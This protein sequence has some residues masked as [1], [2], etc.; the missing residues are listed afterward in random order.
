MEMKSCIAIEF[1]HENVLKF[2]FLSLYASILTEMLAAQFVIRSLQMCS[3]KSHTCYFDFHE[4]LLHCICDVVQLFCR[5]YSVR[6]I[7]HV[8]VLIK[9]MHDNMHSIF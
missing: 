1:V 2:N 8:N 4:L 3:I 9:M 6:V 5:Q 7:N